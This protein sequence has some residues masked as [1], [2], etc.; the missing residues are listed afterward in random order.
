MSVPTGRQ[1]HAPA[2]SWRRPS[3]V[4]LGRKRVEQP[5]GPARR[6]SAAPGAGAGGTPPGRPP[7]PAAENR[8]MP[9]GR[10]AGP[11]QPGHGIDGRRELGA[12]RGRRRRDRPTCRFGITSVWPRSRVR[13]R[14][15]RTRA[16]R[17][18]PS[19]SGSR[20]ATIPQ[21]MQ[22]GR[23]WVGRPCT[24][25]IT[26]S[27]SLAG[28]PAGQLGCDQLVGSREEGGARP[29]DV[30]R[31][32]DVGHLP[33]RVVGRQR[34]GFGDVEGGPEPA[35]A[36]LGEQRVGV[37]QP[38]AGDVDQQRPVGQRGELLVPIRPSVCGVSG[39]ITTCDVGVGSSWGRSLIACTRS[40]SSP[41]ARRATRVTE[42]TSKPASRR[43]IAAPIRPYP[44]I[45][46]RLSASALPN[47]KPHCPGLSRG[48]DVEVPAAG[49]HQRDRQLGGAGV[50]NAG[51]VAQRDAV[52]HDRL[53]VVDAGRL[54]LDDLEAGHLRAGRAVR[55]PSCRG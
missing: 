26:F 5:A 31:D 4:H 35:G 19:G 18:T 41:R 55:R 39:A 25:S 6:R 14:G 40:G 20:P 42:A 53:E 28:R 51:R 46:T 52:R 2:C 33:E 23:R 54:G 11:Q 8:L 43:S 36:R 48:E 30:R 29:A 37:H 22:S 45:S 13:C 17:S 7:A 44:M 49:Q 3:P 15:T 47:A 34:L 12:A 21:K 16:R 24:H 10:R 32:Q 1:A 27:R 9:V 38:A 50:V